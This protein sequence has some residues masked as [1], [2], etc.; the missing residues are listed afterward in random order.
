MHI[1]TLKAQSAMMAA[2]KIEQGMLIEIFPGEYVEVLRVVHGETTS[3]IQYGHETAPR[4]R[5][6]DHT[7]TVC[8]VDPATI[9]LSKAQ[10]TL[11]REAAA[12]HLNHRPSN[13]EW[14]PRHAVRGPMFEVYTGGA[15][16]YSNR[17]QTATALDAWGLLSY[18]PT[19]NYAVDVSGPA[20]VWLKAHPVI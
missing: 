10:A 16:A 5:K 15:R 9:K 13:A 19:V 17:T 3:G 2:A 6:Y 1:P 12:G 14:A 18:N 4:R 7:D 11:L 20:K 8:V